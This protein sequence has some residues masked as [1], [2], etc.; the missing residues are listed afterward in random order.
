MN[1]DTSL[2]PPPALHPFYLSFK[3]RTFR[4]SM[5][6]L[7]ERR[8]LVIVMISNF[9]DL[10]SLLNND[11]DADIPHGSPLGRVANM[12]PFIFLVFQSC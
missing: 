9:K 5:Q 1:L 3:P 4:A 8:P 10:N 12:F 6:K 7:G 11:I 2:D